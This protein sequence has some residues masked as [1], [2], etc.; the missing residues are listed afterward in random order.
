LEETQRP[1]YKST[2]SI[3]LIIAAFTCYTLFFTEPFGGIGY[4]IFQ[5]HLNGLRQAKN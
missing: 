4:A 1:G 5:R 3:Q 2:D